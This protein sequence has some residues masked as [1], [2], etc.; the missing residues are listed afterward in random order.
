M[1]PSRTDTGEVTGKLPIVQHASVLE[2]P[3]RSRR[4]RRVVPSL[5]QFPQDL[6]HR[7]RTRRQ[8]PRRNQMGGLHVGQELQAVSAF[9]VEFHALRQIEF[10]DEFDRNG[11]ESCSVY[12]DY[13]EVSVAFVWF[14]SCDSHW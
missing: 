11:R 3:H 5:T 14:E 7:P 13:R 6:V 4:R 9:I 10:A 8:H 1:P 12:L 2:P